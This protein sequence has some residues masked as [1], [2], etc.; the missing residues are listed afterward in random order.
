MLYSEWSGEQ[1]ARVQLLQTACGVSLHQSS[2]VL[3]TRRTRKLRLPFPANFFS[4]TT[5]V[6]LT[7]LLTELQAYRLAVPTLTGG[8]D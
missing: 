1:P 8:T 2:N 3:C 4:S 7:F 6:N 5:K